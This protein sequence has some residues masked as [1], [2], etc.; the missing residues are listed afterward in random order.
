MILT[1]P[2]KV[3]IQAI[4]GSGEETVIS[5][6]SILMQLI[7]YAVTPGTTFDVT[8]CDEDD[9]ILFAE[10]DYTDT[11]NELLSIPCYGNWKLK[12]DNASNDDLFK[13]I[14]TFRR[15]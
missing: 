10:E 4:T 6:N 5:N 13:C 8:I 12:I 1:V 14:L 9:N 3:N 7:V 2:E 15:S 11:C